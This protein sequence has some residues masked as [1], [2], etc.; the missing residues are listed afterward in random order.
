MVHERGR[1]DWLL[2]IDRA[3][4]PAGNDAPGIPDWRK[5][6]VDG[7]AV[8]LS[9]GFREL[10]AAVYRDIFAGG[11]IGIEESRATIE[12]AFALTVQSGWLQK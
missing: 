12:L 1:C 11:G 5:L 3:D 6:T 10:H 9:A 8:D 4:I 7:E 2:S